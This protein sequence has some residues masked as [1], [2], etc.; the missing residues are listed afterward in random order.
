MNLFQGRPNLEEIFSPGCMYMIYS[1]NDQIKVYFVEHINESKHGV[2]E[3]IKENTAVTM[4][5]EELQ[6]L[7]NTINALLNDP[8]VAR[9]L[10]KP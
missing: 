1:V 7:A 9:K 2:I 3:N 5:I 10:L 6:K 4:T 8:I